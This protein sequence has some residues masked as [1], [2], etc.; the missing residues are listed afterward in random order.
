MSLIRF[1]GV[2]PKVL[3]HNYRFEGEDVAWAQKGVVV[4]VINGKS[5]ML[6]Q[7]RIVDAV[8]N[9]VD[10]ILLGVD[11]VFWVLML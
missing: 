7:E 3:I 5:I 2:H 8:F 4:N 10:I 9:D 1:W 6:I 11:K